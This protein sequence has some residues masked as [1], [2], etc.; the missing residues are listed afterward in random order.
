MWGRFPGYRVVLLVILVLV[1]SNFFVI[2]TYAQVPVTEAN[3]TLPE[4]EIKLNE[5]T[6]KS[7]KE[8]VIEQ[9]LIDEL[10][11]Q[12]VK[13]ILIIIYFDNEESVKSVINQENISVLR[14]YGDYIKTSSTSNIESLSKREGISNIRAVINPELDAKL[15]N[16]NNPHMVFLQFSHDLTESEKDMLVSLGVNIDRI[17]PTKSA[18]VFAPE[19]AIDELAQLDFVIRINDAEV[20]VET[21]S[22]GEERLTWFE[23]ID[24]VLSDVIK[25][26]SSFLSNLFQ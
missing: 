4:S 14:N 10:E 7:F 18:R 25:G 11:N 13:H 9:A 23:K 8:T 17:Y 19:N 2:R 1:I 24:R 12:E 20:P 3:E 6:N 22:P 26:I 16:T 5:T 15:T 21:R